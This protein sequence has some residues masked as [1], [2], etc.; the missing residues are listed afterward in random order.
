MA[1][2]LH[3][4]GMDM[5]SI[6]RKGTM[7]GTL[8]YLAPEM[9]KFN[10]ATMGTDIWALGCIIFKMLTGNVPFSG[11][12]T[13]SVF[14]KIVNKDLEYP[15]TLSVEAVAL[16]DSMLMLNPNERLGAPDSSKGID[17]LKKHPFFN[18]IDFTNPKSLCISE[19]LRRYIEG[20]KEVIPE[21]IP[22]KSIFS[23]D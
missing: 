16:I 1:D 10:S 19:E 21:F 12:N 17:G 8:N 18:G 7:V 3:M 22:R 11:T 15:E 6:G 23:L 13:Y 20:E 4:D 14:P 9:I 2:L 5:E